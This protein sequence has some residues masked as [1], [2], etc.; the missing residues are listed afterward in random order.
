VCDVQFKTKI[1][2]LIK[3]EESVIHTQEMVDSVEKD[4][5]W[6]KMLNLSVNDFNTMLK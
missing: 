3:N 5:H 6:T 2:M 1:V 4:A